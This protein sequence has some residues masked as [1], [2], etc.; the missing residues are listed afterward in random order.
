M[1]AEDSER[2][3]ISDAKLSELEGK[4]DALGYTPE[5]IANKGQAGGYAELDSQGTVPASQL[6]ANVK[7]I[8][9]VANIAARDALNQ[10]EGMRAHVVDASADST[11]DSGWAEYLSDGTNWTKTAE[12]ESID[13]VQEWGNIVGRPSSSPSAIDGAVSNAHTHSNKSALDK[14]TDSGSESSY[15]LAQFLTPQDIEDLG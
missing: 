8:H 13:V 10:F 1:I 3:F 5:D 15:D 6:P 11:V 12:K 7:E 9:V 4:Q 2:R 14:I